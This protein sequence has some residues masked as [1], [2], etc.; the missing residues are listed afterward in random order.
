MAR[1]T[2]VYV[3]SGIKE[4][5]NVKKLGAQRASTHFDNKEKPINYGRQLVK[6][7]DLGQLKIQKRDGTFQIEFTY[8]KGPFPPE[9]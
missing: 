8:R 1:R 9:E 4:G 2:I 7:A 3:G 5:W 6:K